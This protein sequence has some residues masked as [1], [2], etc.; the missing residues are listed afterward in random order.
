[1]L[2]LAC[3]Y[4]A[5]VARW[6]EFRAKRD[7]QAGVG[8][9]ILIGATIVN[10]QRRKDAIL[11]GEYTWIAGQLLVYPH[12][13]QIRIGSYCYVG[14][15]TKIWSADEVSI[16]DRVFLAH[17]VNIHD[18]DAHSLSAA[19]RHQHY[20]ELVTTGVAS[21]VERVHAHRVRIEDD[22]WIGFNSTLLKGVTIG[23]GAIVGACA[24]VTRDVP[25]YTIVAGNPAV[26][27][28]ESQS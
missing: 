19:E 25:P 9:R 21:F 11:I 28:G 26:V 4:A 20:R 16:G 13:G 27:I 5:L 3:G 15:W 24:V 7:C 17:G 1:M 12:R 22:A 8:S 2:N 10:P 14:E 6:H 23:K 18:N